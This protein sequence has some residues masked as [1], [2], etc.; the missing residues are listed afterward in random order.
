MQASD[1]QTGEFDATYADVEIDDA[2]I[3]R[4]E[5][6]V[7]GE[8]WK[9]FRKVAGYIPFADDL[10]AGYYCAMDPNTPVRVRG[11]LLGALA[12]FILPID[13]VPDFIAGF[14]FTD[15]AAVLATAISM[16]SRHMN[17]KHRIA[18]AKALGKALPPGSDTT[19]V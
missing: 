3:A 2:S 16:V 13:A 15:D 7:R 5:K 10:V 18:A 8:F 6:K 14:G 4:R 12:Y 19:P 9:K 11:V 1:N 17:E